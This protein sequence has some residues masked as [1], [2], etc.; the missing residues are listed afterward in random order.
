VFTAGNIRQQGRYSKTRF[1]EMQERQLSIAV[2]IMRYD[3][4]AYWWC[5]DKYFWEDDDLSA[6]DVYALAYERYL[7]TQ[8]KLERA[9]TAVATGAAAALP[10]RQAIPVEMRRAV[11][12]RDAGMCAECGSNF[13]IQYDHV[14]PVALGGAT[15]V[16]NMQILCAPCNQSKGATLG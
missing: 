13:D 1:Q 14:I 3:G 8:K 16:E 7:R 6:R 5:G 9:R 11:F 4:R 10:R 2:E 15:T 12:S